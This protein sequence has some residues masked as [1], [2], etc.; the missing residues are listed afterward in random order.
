M[1][2]KGLRLLK[3]NGNNINS[4]LNLIIMT[5]LSIQSNDFCAP[6]ST[7]I[8]V[9]NP[10]R[11]PIR[12]NYSHAYELLHDPNNPIQWAQWNGGTLTEAIGWIKALESYKVN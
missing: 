10:G 9:E 4:Q 5:I 3:D 6:A 2:G 11:L 8:M 1:T 12:F 7:I